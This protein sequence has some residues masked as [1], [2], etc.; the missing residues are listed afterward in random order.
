MSPPPFPKARRADSPDRIP[1]GSVCDRGEGLP[2]IA[3]SAEGA[4][5]ALGEA[6]VTLSLAA[7]AMPG[8]DFDDRWNAELVRD[9]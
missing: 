1:R 7:I 5:T 8:G 3:G 6:V 4:E 2:S 9:A